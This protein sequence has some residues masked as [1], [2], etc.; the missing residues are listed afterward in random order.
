MYCDDTVGIWIRVRNRVRGRS[1]VKVRVGDRIRVGV[2]V[3][4]T[5]DD[6]AGYSASVLIPIGK[7]RPR[8]RDRGSVKVRAR[9]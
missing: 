8:V 9:V 6:T 1:R 2:Q 7:S 4:V 5:C 3:G